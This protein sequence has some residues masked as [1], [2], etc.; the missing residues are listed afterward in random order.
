MRLGQRLK[1]SGKGLDEGLRR[2]RR[3]ERLLGHGPGSANA[4]AAHRRLR[5]ANR[6]RRA[7]QNTSWPAEIAKI[8]ITRKMTR[9]IKNRILEICAA[10]AATPVKP[11]APATSEINRQM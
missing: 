7:L 5:S 9:K 11:S 8:K 1:P 2:G 10:P 4:S 3:A 6:L